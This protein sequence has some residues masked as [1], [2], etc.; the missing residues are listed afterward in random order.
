MKTLKNL[1]ICAILFCSATSCSDFLD[2]EPN[3]L[4]TGNFYQ[5]DEEA[6]QAVN[7]VYNVFYNFYQNHVGFDVDCLSDD[8]VKGHGTDFAD[9]NSF[10]TGQMLASNAAIKSLWSDYYAGIYRANM[11]LD[12]VKEQSKVSE[13]KKKQVLGES[14]FLRAYFYYQLVQRYGGVPIILTTIDQP[15]SPAR[16]TVE[17]VY[18]QIE[19]DLIDAIELLEYAS[20]AVVGRPNKGTAICLLGL[21]YLSQNNFSDCYKTLKPVVDNKDGKYNYSLIQDLS[22][23]YQ[24]SNNNGPESVF[25]IQAREA[26]PLGQTMA[27]NHWVRPRGM[28]K[29]GGLGFPM[30]TLS[31]YNEFEPGDLRREATILKEGDFIASELVDDEGNN[32]LFQASWAPETGMNCAK[33]VKWVNVGDYQERSGQNKKLIRYAE[34][35]LAFAEAAYA[36]NHSD[37]AWKAIKTIRQRAFGTETPTMYS[38]DFI[39]ALRHERRVELATE[40]RRYF[41]LIRWGIAEQVLTADCKKH[42]NYNL[43]YSYNKLANGLYPIPQAELDVNNNPGFAQNEGYK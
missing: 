19:E 23:M 34:V 13:I 39:T 33:Y 10:N 20:D 26:A 32:I 1:I 37:E 25:E 24:I 12:N 9:Y 21:V 14:Y 42:T 35:L 29:R 28:S 7:A 27:Y 17:V 5:T 30:P 38:S 6:E 2:K 22:K 40:N 4:G 43:P 8:I 31:L 16:E 15:K 18:G 41:D 11:V 3:Q 36:E